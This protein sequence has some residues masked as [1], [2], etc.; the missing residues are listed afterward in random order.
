MSISVH[1]YSKTKKQVIDILEKH[2]P[3]QAYFSFYVEAEELLGGFSIKVGLETSFQGDNNKVMN[4]FSDEI[5][6]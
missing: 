5:N 6:D 1:G 2:I 4:L 3:D